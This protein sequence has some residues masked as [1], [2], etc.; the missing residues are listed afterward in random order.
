MLDDRG[1]TESMR[2][3]HDA[4]VCNSQHVRDMWSHYLGPDRTKVSPYAAP[5]RAATLANLP[6]AYVIT[7][8]HDPL[9][10]EGLNYAI[11]L[12]QAGVPV[13]LHNYAGT[14]HGFDLLIPGAKVSS[15]AFD[16][17]V[18]AFRRATT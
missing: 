8:E 4:L 10:D 17:C 18:A 2:T 13:E 11:L 12:L 5:A 15:R 14:V 9:R 1:G 7:C 3:G 16:E 6:P